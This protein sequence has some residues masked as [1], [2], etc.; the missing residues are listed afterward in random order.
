MNAEA[1][2]WGRSTLALLRAGP[3]RR[4]LLGTSISD[5]G[6]WMQM[7][8]QGW[9]MSGLT[10]KAIMLGLVNFASGLPMIFLVMLGGSFADRGDKRKILIW[11]QIVQIALAL[12]LGGLIY[13]GKIQ[14]WH[15]IAVAGLLGIAFA[16]EH[17]ALSALVPELVRQEEIASAVALDRAVFHGSRL[18]GPAIA[19]VVVSVWNTATAFFANAFTFIA[20]IIALVSL[21]PRPVGSHEEEAMRASGIKD[22][23]RYV[24]ADRPSLAMVGMIAVMTICIFPTVS[25]MMPLYVRDVLQLGADKLGFI[26]AGSGLG[27]IF[28]AIALIMI[29]RRHRAAGMATAAAAVSLAVLGLS[30]VHGFPLAFAAL[31]VTSLGLSLIF[32]LSNTIVQERAP[33]H[34]RGRVSAVM[35]LSFFGL[36]PIAGL[37]VT[38]LADAIGMR[39]SLAFSSV[40]Y[41]IGSLAI[42]GW[43]GAQLNQTPAPA[44]PVAKTPPEVAA[45]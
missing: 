8:A 11:T 9:V 30:Q 37:G 25:V 33:N 43:I 31:L 39:T 23:F 15:V 10:N 26:M 6:T 29:P 40:L 36:M 12:I 42:L 17:P 34:L 16:F 28:G 7:M 22:G 27:S 20:L 18:L 32:G 4:Y 19:G 5:T 2:P 38:S 44:T 24:R 13:A 1:K 35:G 45:V 41:G 14:I 3:F 21:P